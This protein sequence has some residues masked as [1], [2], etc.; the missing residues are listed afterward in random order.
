M[1]GSS[2]AYILGVFFVVPGALLTVTADALGKGR[3]HDRLRRS[4]SHEGSPRLTP[5]RRYA[6][7]AKAELTS[8]QE[9]AQHAEIDHLG[10]IWELRNHALRGARLLQFLLAEVR[11]T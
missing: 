4:L 9:A 5:E 1:L 3:K 8:R 10:S 7:G 6:H 11:K 2:L